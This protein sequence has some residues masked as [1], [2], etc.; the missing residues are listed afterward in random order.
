LEQGKGW[1][2]GRIII[3]ITEQHFLIDFGWG[4]IFYRSV[5][6]YCLE[7]SRIARREE[8]VIVAEYMKKSN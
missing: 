3:S 2:H 7:L 8:N 1:W 4:D 6:K 5:S